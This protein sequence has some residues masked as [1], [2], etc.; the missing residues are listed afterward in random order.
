MYTEVT[1]NSI[2]VSGHLI[3]WETEELFG[4]EVSSAKI[5]LSRSVSSVISITSGLDVTIKR[6]NTTATDQFIFSGYVDTIEKQGGLITIVCIDKMYD[7]LKTQMT[8]SYDANTDTYAGEGGE[9]ARD[10]IETHGGMSATIVATPT[11][12]TITKFICNNVSV[13]SKLK[14]VADVYDYSIFYDPDDSTIHFEP[15]GYTTSAN[16]LTVGDNVQKLPKWVYD[17][18]QMVN[19]LKV[20]GAEQIVETTELF[21]GTA[22]ANQTNTLTKKP[23]DVVVSLAGTE[24][25]PG[26]SGVTSGAYD[27]EIDKEAKK[28]N[29]NQSTDPPIAVD[30]IS[31]TYTYAIPIPVW[32]QDD[33]SIASYS[34]IEAA[35]H[36]SN[37]Q[38]LD[39]AEVVGRAYLAKYSEPFVSTVISV[40]GVID[41]DTGNKVQLLDT[42]Q[43]ENR[44]LIIN[45]VVRKYP[46]TGDELYLGDKEWRLA[47][48]GSVTMERIKRLEEL[49]SKNEDLLV[50]VKDLPHSMNILKRYIIVYSVN[51]AGDSMI[52]G[53][54]TFG[55]WGV[56]KWGDNATY[57]F[58]LGSSKAGILGTSCLGSNLS[59]ETMERIMWPDKTYK[60]NFVDTDF[61]NASTTAD[62]AD[63]SGVCTFTNGEIAVSEIVYDNNVTITRAKLTADS[64]TNLTFHMSVDGTN[65][66]SCTSGTTLTFANV[67]RELQWKATASGVASLSNINI[68]ITG[69]G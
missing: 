19:R 27:Y 52:W 33:T 46:H 40:S 54:P 45:K 29:W 37:I 1:I 18:S 44:Y 59:P 17:K 6:G 23:I 69:G 42:T 35:K 66:E 7:L 15:K 3:K 55:V 67:G 13:F 50:T 25:V 9:L 51:I 64:T 60:E 5:I 41:Y 36:F 53:N 68:E 62:W 28:I 12:I 38:T 22:A 14:E 20:L 48:W 58:I 4:Q 61:E 43:S 63:V 49:N 47:D 39:D 56:S 16:I 24:Q 57:S 26:V 31:V 2:D 32:V 34:T 10:L 8:Y 11:D 65:W 21:S 30:N